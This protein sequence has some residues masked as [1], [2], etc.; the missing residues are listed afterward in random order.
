[1]FVSPVLKGNPLSTLLIIPKENKNQF[2][3]AIEHN[4][5]T[6]TSISSN[7]ILYGDR[8]FAASLMVKTFVGSNHPSRHYRITSSLSLGMIGKVA[9]AHQIQQTIHKWINDTDPQGWQYQIK[10]D[11]ILNYEVGIE[12]SIFLSR[13][14][15]FN[16][17][18][19]G[20]VGTLNT[21]FSLGSTIM[22]GKLNSA[23][24]SAFSNVISVQKQKIN[25]HL[26][27][28]PVINTV[29]YDAT[30]QGGMIFNLDSPYTLSNKEI[31]HFTFQGNAGVVFTLGSFNIEYFQSVISKEFTTSHYHRWG[32]LRIG[33]FF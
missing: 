1:E 22:L 3:L 18:A 27:A 2:G 15:L 13:Y 33:I 25:F 17:L 10:N 24:T 4:A 11:L 16:G 8:P 14:F 5:Y 20:R 6:P 26:Y 31:E 12:K 30:L 32:G 28:Q 19:S 29:I 21:K 7:K 9:G 23:I